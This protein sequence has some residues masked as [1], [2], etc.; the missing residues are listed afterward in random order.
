M[1]VPSLRSMH[2]DDS[3]RN[4]MGLLGFHDKGIYRYL[5]LFHVDICVLTL[6]NPWSDQFLINPHNNTTESF[7]KIM[8]IWQMITNL[9][10]FDC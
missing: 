4:L 2:L 6:M 5:I 10:T 3:F 7:F 8:R 1:R 9:T